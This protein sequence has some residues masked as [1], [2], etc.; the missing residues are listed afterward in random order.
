[1]KIYWA[2]HRSGYPCAA[3]SASGDRGKKK[4][5]SGVFIH[6]KCPGHI[7]CYL[8]VKTILI[9]IDCDDDDDDDIRNYDPVP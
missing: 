3:G 8:E 5:S 1:M 7:G 4:N 2:V 9:L 6:S